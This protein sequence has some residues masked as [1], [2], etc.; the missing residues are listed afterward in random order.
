MNGNY[1]GRIDTSHVS[2][3][4]SF[5]K[6]C[7]HR[8]A[9]DLL[10]LPV[11]SF[12]R[13]CCALLHAAKARTMLSILWWKTTKFQKFHSHFF[14]FR[15]ESVQR[16]KRLS[17]VRQK[18]KWKWRGKGNRFEPECER[19]R[20]LLSESSEIIHTLSRLKPQATIKIIDVSSDSRGRVFLSPDWR[21]A[22]FLQ[23]S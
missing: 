17:Q 12:P 3:S 19:T 20:E 18:R 13:L 8:E 7:R 5:S 6:L 11:C 9:N 15:K 1:T 10:D 16:F 22:D 21:G 14:R 23:N 4:K 2:R